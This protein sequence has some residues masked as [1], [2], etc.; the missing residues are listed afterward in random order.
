M[1]VLEMRAGFTNPKPTQ[2]DVDDGEFGDQGV[3]A[4]GVTRTAAPAA[5]G[6]PAR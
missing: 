6:G 4:V 5:M 2:S 3:A 1:A